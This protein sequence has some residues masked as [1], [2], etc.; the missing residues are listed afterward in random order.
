M[1][2][3]VLFAR[4]GGFAFLAGR[5]GALKLLDA[6][7]QL[8]HGD[9][10]LLEGSAADAVRRMGDSL[11]MGRARRDAE[12]Q[13]KRMQPEVV[14]DPVLAFL[15]RIVAGGPKSQPLLMELDHLPEWWRDRDQRMTLSVVV[16]VWSNGC[17]SDWIADVRTR[18][19]SVGDGS[20]GG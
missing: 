17:W 6:V 5:A 11:R 14:V 12:A 1:S 10:F 13:L 8:L 15:D 9:L 18:L 7:L 19:D 20:V 16:G 4:K 2:R 3:R